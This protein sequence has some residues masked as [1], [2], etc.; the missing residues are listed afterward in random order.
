MPS[1]GICDYPQGRCS[2]NSNLPSINVVWNCQSP[3][4]RCPLP[5]PR[6]GSFCTVDGMQCDYGTCAVPGGTMETCSGG[7]WTQAMI[8]CGL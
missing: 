8:A 3:Q 7:V 5:R 1:G 6:L 2:C 4:Q